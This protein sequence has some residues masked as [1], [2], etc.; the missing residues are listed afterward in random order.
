MSYYDEEIEFYLYDTKS[1]QAGEPIEVLWKLQG[2][3][4]WSFSKESGDW[5]FIPTSMIPDK[6]RVKRITEQEAILLMC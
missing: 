1:Y 6:K 5:I 4:W 3:I 2:G